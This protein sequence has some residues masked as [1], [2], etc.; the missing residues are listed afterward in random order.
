MFFAYFSSTDLAYDLIAAADVIQSTWISRV[1]SSPEEYQRTMACL[2]NYHLVERSSNVYRIEPQIH[3]WLVHS[4]SSGP[5]F[6]TF[7]MALRCIAFSHNSVAKTSCGHKSRRF[8]QHAEHITSERFNSMWR[9][10]MQDSS[11]IEAVI[12]LARCY[13]RWNQPEKAAALA[14]P[15]MTARQQNQTPALSITAGAMSDL[16]KT[17]A[18]QGQR[19]EAEQLYR[20]AIDVFDADPLSDPTLR[21]KALRRLGCLY[22]SL[23]RLDECEAVLKTLLNTRLSSPWQ[24]R[25]VSNIIRAYADLGLCRHEQGRYQQALALYRTALSDFE[26]CA[27]RNDTNV[28]LVYTRTGDTYYRTGSFELA[29]QAY[30]RAMLGYERRFGRNYKRTVNLRELLKKFPQR[31]RE[32]V[33]EEQEQTETGHSAMLDCSQLR[34][35]SRGVH[36]V[37]DKRPHDLHEARQEYVREWIECCGGDGVASGAGIKDG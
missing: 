36:E 33:G 32:K 28:L 26:S 24:Y 13:R 27:E 37:T 15:V 9:F 3:E 18:K 4:L 11:H 20:Q 17:L 6:S 22:G 8:I 12:A 7:I 5:L 16:A 35:P 1:T 30:T 21:L 14:T 2:Q 25:D 29:E 34:P 23:G 19:Q 10:A 31:E